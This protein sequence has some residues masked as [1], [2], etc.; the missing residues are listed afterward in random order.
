MFRSIALAT[1]MGF[2]AFG[3]A[4]AQDAAPE[5][6]QIEGVVAVVNDDPISFTDVRQRARLLLLSLGGQRTD[7]GA[8]PTAHRRKHSNNSSMS[9]FNFRKQ[10][11]MKSRSLTV[12]SRDQSIAWRSNRV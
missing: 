9:A 8:D 7:T 6:L 4:S 3:Y 1:L 11:N 2:T 5:T 10:L 12:R